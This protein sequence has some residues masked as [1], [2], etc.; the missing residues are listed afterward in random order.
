[1][2]AMS[3]QRDDDT[4]QT[5][6]EPRP[7]ALGAAEEQ[8]IAEDEKP[9]VTDFLKAATKGAKDLKKLEP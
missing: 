1:M 3:G 8:D 2:R 9:G 6:E 5:P 7:D 4:Q